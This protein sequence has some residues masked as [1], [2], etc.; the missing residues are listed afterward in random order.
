[1]NPGRWQQVEEI[2]HAALECAESERADFLDKAC[3]SDGALR[4][5]VELLLIHDQQAKDF[6]E[7]PALEAVAKALAQVSERSA[8]ET[9]PIPPGQTISHYRIV[10]KL[11]GGGMGVVYK[12]EDLELGRFVALKFLPE[13]FARH[14]HALERFHREARAASAL[15]HPNIC[16]IYEI[17]KHNGQSFIA[18][19][20]LDGLTLKHRIAGH[21]LETQLL[22][23]LAIEI[24]DGLGAAHAR[25]I[26]H[27]DIKPANIFVTSSSRVKILDFGLAKLLPEVEVGAEKG[28]ALNLEESL[29]TPGTLLGTLPYMSPE[30]IRGGRVDARSDL[31]SFGAVVYEMATGTR[32]FPGETFGA[33]I[34]EV[35]QLVP[36]PPTRLN[37]SLPPGVD[38]IVSKA[39]EKNRDLRYQS[40]GEVLTHLKRLE[41]DKP[42]LLVQRKPWLT[43]I[44]TAMAVLL[45]ATVSYY[46]LRKHK[47]TGSALVHGRPSVAVLGFKNLS[48][49]SD[50]AWLS[51]ALSE[52]LTTELAAGEKLRTVPGEDVAHAK[53][54]L[55]LPDTDALS[56]ETLG[57]LR[58]NLSSDFVVLGSYLD[59]GDEAEGR[60]RLDLRLQDAASGETLASVTESGSEADVSDLISRAG[61]KLRQ[62]LGV[63]AVS[64][65]DAVAV[66]ASLPSNPEAARFYSEGLAKMRAF[67]NQGAVALLQDAVQREPSFALSHAALAGA[68]AGLG[69]DTRAQEEAKKALDLSDR[70]SREE[71]LWVEGR[72]RETVS[73][74][75]RAAEIY[76]S[77]FQTFPD[78]LDYGL[79]LVDARIS[80][81][82]FKEALAVVANIRKLP[83]PAGDDPRFDLAE[84]RASYF[85]SN[86]NAVVAAAE[87]AAQKGTSS[88][89]RL[90]VAHARKY[91]GWG[92][93][94]LG[95]AQLALVAY[96]EAARLFEQAGDRSEMG[97][98]IGDTGL[99]YF[100]RGDY[101]RAIGLYQ[102]ALTIHRQ[103]GN[104]EREANWLMDLAA[105]WDDVGKQDDAQKGYVQALAIWRVIG[106]RSGEADTLSNLANL[107]S[108]REEYLDATVNTDRALRIFRDIGDK[109]STAITLSNL[110]GH[111]RIQGN[112]REALA[113]QNEGLN[114]ARETGSNRTIA[115]AL[116]TLGLLQADQDDL[117][118][119]RRHYEEAQSLATPGEY[120]RDLAITEG[121]LADLSI[122]EGHA[123]QAEL[124]ARQASEEFSNERH[125]N[126]ELDAYEV[127]ARAFL[128]Q[129]KVAE[130]VQLIGTAH[131]RVQLSQVSPLNR[132]MF[133][134]TAARVRAAAGSSTEARRAL[135]SS[136]AHAT[137]VGCWLG[138][139]K[140]RLA[141]NEI[142]LRF[143][144]AAAGRTHLQQLEQEARVRGFLL[145]ARE[146][147][148]MANEAVPFA[149]TRA[150]GTF[151]LPR[152]GKI[153]ISKKFEHHTVSRTALERR[154]VEEFLDENGTIVIKSE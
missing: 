29:S 145:M 16:T 150:I 26:V 124:L 93:E 94:S 75:D 3:S 83:P 52:M 15:N 71:R 98:I 147:A 35:L 9:G 64:A 100:N 54:D 128:A 113:A 140:A 49:R 33:V 22:L 31:F 152:T 84:A 107:Q 73:D 95:Q 47:E 116:N 78:N 11:G 118:N 5:Q 88:G 149:K 85:V 50:A 19:E 13:E 130:A 1:M 76:Q 120:K 72:Y 58:R 138:Q 7:S 117:A 108:E 4:R 27:R 90:I 70:L 60:V 2:Y 28:P 20:Y 144:N 91:Q 151:L 134:I 129:G 79:R 63:G 67:D 36:P 17:G 24:A 127:W 45:A 125:P 112:L 105:A 39:L 38:P 123:A 148:A 6:L 121:L 51:P 139:F 41:G 32:A 37:P 89:A 136:L 143:G 97:N 42:S 106:N 53:I 103:L 43:F 46:L 65:E 18:M 14:G 111:L 87:R 59:L 74:W 96:G 10:E 141:L 21:P 40:A 137:R 69:Y 77:L 12:A 115:V 122:E 92:L 109:A 132:L 154:A 25:G 126:G 110:A 34:G 86:S 48:G 55:S 61:A 56:R 102:Q 133:E 142:E 68:W 66:R 57:R 131:D 80:A 62:R 153:K 8:R 81:S 23:E 44:A 82:K 104:K 99:L 101:S 135:E 30:Q 146:A 114:I 119:A